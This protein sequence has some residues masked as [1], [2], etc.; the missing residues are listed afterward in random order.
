[1]RIKSTYLIVLF[2]ISL[3]SCG[4]KYEYWDI[5]QFNMDKNAL[6][7]TEEVKLLY[8]SRG[9]DNNPDDVY[10]YHMVAVSQ[11]TGDT[12]NILTAV[13]NGIT[14]KDKNRI[15]S[16]FNENNAVSKFIQMDLDKMKE[17]KHVD[18]LK[19]IDSKQI[20]KVARDPEYDYIAKNDFPTVIGVIGISP[21][22]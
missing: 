7:D 1:M 20:A 8:C 6:S 21:N 10:Y 11:K 4:S 15:F 3:S 13:D 14:M 22:N 19:N 16:Y 9:P 5:S 17:I 12:V 2:L 18:D